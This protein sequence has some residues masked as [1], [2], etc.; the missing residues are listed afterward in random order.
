MV[1]LN[2]IGFNLMSRQGCYASGHGDLDL[3]LTD[4]KSIGI[5][6]GLWPTKTPSM[7][8][9]SLIGLKLLSRQGFYVQDH[10]NLDL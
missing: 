8:S 10:R 7:V 4:P 6:Y 2:L 1:T 9:Q 3:L 5:I